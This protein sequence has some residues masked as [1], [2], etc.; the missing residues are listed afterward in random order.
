[1][2]A[3]LIAAVREPADS[4]SACQRAATVMMASSV[5][6]RP[7]EAPNRLAGRGQLIALQLRKSAHAHQHK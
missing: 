2:T 3:S 1:L 7:N 4:C 5:S 6:P